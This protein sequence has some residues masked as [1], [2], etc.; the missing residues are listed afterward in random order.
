MSVSTI[1]STDDLDELRSEFRRVCRVMLGVEF[2][3]DVASGELRYAYKS[4]SLTQG[5]HDIAHG[6]EHIGCGT[7][8]YTG[9]PATPID[10]RV[11][12]TDH[13]KFIEFAT[14]FIV[15]LKAK[16]QETLRAEYAKAIEAFGPRFA[17]QPGRIRLEDLFRTKSEIEPARS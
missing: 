1:D 2:N 16:A 9:V 3:Y 17:F 15:G 4:E 13:G 8:K 14:D 10:H 7:T 12:N 11:I 5:E 6:A